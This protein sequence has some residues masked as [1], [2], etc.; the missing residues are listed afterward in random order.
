M[1]I[2]VDFDNTIVCYDRIFHN[3]ALEKSLISKNLPV[4]KGVVRDYLRRQDKED[5]WTEL[6]GHVYGAR[7]VEADPFPAVC[8]FF[9]ECRE[10]SVPVFII[11]HRTRYPFLGEKY[12]LHESA[13]TWLRKYGFLNKSNG[14][15]APDRVF[16]ELTKSAKL[17]R[18]GA[19]MCDY[20]ID[21]L[22]EFLAEPDFPGN[23]KKILFDPNNHYPDTDFR[24]VTSWQAIRDIFF[25]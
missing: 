20:F 4:N 7:M 15:L 10:K 19:A 16:F 2:G 11:S 12:D 1:R 24:R 23:T 21:D 18:I 25:D 14:L 5:V 3:I 22:P 9:A 6:Q 17:E 8:D 13:H